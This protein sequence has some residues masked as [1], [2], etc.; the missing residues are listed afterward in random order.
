LCSA[1]TPPPRLAAQPWSEVIQFPA[2]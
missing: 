1:Q 2:P